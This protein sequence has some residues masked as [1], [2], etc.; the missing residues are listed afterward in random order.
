[1]RYDGMM[2]S[3]LTMLLV[4]S[5][6]LL[7]VLGAVIL[8]LWIALEL[9]RAGDAARLPIG[10]NDHN[11]AQQ[12]PMEILQRRYARGEVGRDEYERVRIDLRRGVESPASEKIGRVTT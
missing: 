2:G 11:T 1:M 12:T 4:M 10:E 6:L 7:V 8:L 3:W 5:S 9:A